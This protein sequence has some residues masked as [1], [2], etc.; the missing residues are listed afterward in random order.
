MAGREPKIDN[1]L[2]FACSVIEYIGRE[3]KNRRVDVVRQLGEKEIERLIDLADVLH[4]EPIENTAEDLI[5]KR[6]ITAGGF[7][8]V[9]E[10]KYNL[11]TVFDIAK[12]YKRLIVSI[13]E[14]QKLPP[15]A[16]LFAAYSS[17]IGAKIDDYNCSMYF[18]N[19]QY[20]YESYIAGEPLKD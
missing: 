20:I 11:P 13:A 19:P 12:V 9:G 10:C 4:C 14:I 2:F 5:E 8:N 7:D 17:P 6:G 15:T 18:E 3:T 16:A 1:D